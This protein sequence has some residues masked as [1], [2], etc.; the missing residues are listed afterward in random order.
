VIAAPHK[1]AELIGLVREIVATP[2]KNA[3]ANPSRYEPS[4]TIFWMSAKYL[5]ATSALAR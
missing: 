1:A 5:L 2:M 4:P 3:T